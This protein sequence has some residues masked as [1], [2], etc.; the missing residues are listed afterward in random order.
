MLSIKLDFYSGKASIFD[1]AKY[2]LRRNE[3]SKFDACHSALQRNVELPDV[4]QI[5]NRVGDGADVVFVLHSGDG[6]REHFH[7]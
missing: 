5:L 6:D 3:S 1:G 2:V 7:W 4:W